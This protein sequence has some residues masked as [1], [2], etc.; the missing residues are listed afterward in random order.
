MLSSC[1]ESTA[2]GKVRAYIA[3]YVD[4]V[5]ANRALLQALAEISSG[6][7][8]REGLRLDQLGVAPEVA[9]GL[10]KVDLDTIRT[11]GLGDDE[12]AGLSARSVDT[13]IPVAIDKAL[14]GPAVRVRAAVPAGRRTKSDRLQLHR[15]TRLDVTQ[16]RM[17]ADQL[18]EM[19]CWPAPSSWPGEPSALVSAMA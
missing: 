16:P 4:Y 18:W 9:A 17:A 7:P 8:S 2:A 19:P 3:A 5:M 11:A 14:H 13:T 15:T 12:L 6:Y 10:A 1:G